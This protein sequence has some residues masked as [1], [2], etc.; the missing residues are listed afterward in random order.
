MTETPIHPACG[1]MMEPEEYG[2][3]RLRPFSHLSDSVSPEE[4][5]FY[6]NIVQGLAHQISHSVEALESVGAMLRELAEPEFGFEPDDEL[7]EAIR[8]SK[9]VPFDKKH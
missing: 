4:R 7:K 3:F 8:D 5:E 1:I 6:E 2:T 9:V